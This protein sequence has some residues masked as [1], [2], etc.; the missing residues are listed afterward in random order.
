MARRQLTVG[1]SVAPGIT[2][3]AVVDDDGEDAVYLVWNHRA[4]CP[5]ACKVYA[6]PADARHEAAML[7]ALE[8]PNIVRGLGTGRPGYF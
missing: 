2:V 1:M 8:H 4:W 6:R 3:L 7:D 5:M